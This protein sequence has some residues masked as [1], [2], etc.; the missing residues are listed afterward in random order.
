MKRALAT[1]GSDGGHWRPSGKT[2]DEG[3]TAKAAVGPSRL[4]CRPSSF[5]RVVAVATSTGGPAALHRLLSGLPDDFPAPIL[6]VQHNAPGFMTG[7]FVRGLEFCR[8]QFREPARPWKTFVEHHVMARLIGRVRRIS[9]GAFLLD[10][11]P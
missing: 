2:K 8:D 11:V 5:S 9:D 7:L 4:G 6:V 10:A 3:P 1:C